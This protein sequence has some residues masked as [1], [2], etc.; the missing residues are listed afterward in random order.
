MTHSKYQQCTR[1]VMDTTDPQIV[2]DEL[3]HC[4][5][6]N[7]LFDTLK[8]PSYTKKY[9]EHNLRQLVKKMKASGRGKEYDCILGLSGGIDS[10]YTAYLLKKFGLRTLLV[11]MDNGWNAEEAV[12]N[13]KNISDILQF[14][15]ES[16]VLDWEE[17]KDLQLSFLRASV[18]EADTPTDIAIL[19]ALHMVAAK[20]KVQYIISGGNLATEG[21]L[22]GNWHYNAK[23]MRYLKSI[24]S[25]FGKRPLRNFPSFGL[26]KES[27]YKFFKGIRMVYLLNY[28]SFSKTEAREILK[29]ELNWEYYG[30][31]H[32]ESRYTKFI[33]SYL[34]PVKFNLDYRKATLSSQICA[35]EICR[36]KALEML[37]QPIYNPEE[38]EKEKRFVAKKLDINLCELEQ[39]IQLPP[40]TYRDYPNN[41]KKLEF[42]YR[43]YRKFFDKIALTWWLIIKLKNSV[44]LE[45]QL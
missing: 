38:V 18:I 44:A 1:C 19:G 42:F 34:L 17:F 9:N 39:I 45:E 7:E 4:N 11:H 15:Y 41:E 8:A 27:W 20:Y 12:R 35:G 23:D 21:I 43:L 29:K 33:Q 16:Y 14:D 40:K 10:S 36:E 13:M 25:Q 6:C 28:I 22:P 2:F 24:H 37:Q 3:G 30:G 26:V 31:K 32:H 5:H